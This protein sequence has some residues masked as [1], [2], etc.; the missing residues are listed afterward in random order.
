M[1]RQYI[2]GSKGKKP[3]SSSAKAPVEAPNTLQSKNTAGIIDLISE[4]EIYGLVNGAKSIFFD[5][6]PL[7]NDDDSYNFNGVVWEEKKGTPDDTP[8][9]GFPY[10][11]TEVDVGV[12]L[13]KTNPITRQ[14]LDSNLDAIRV[15][16]RIPQLTVANTSTGD[17]SGGTVSFQIEVQSSGGSYELVNF[18]N[19]ANP[20]VI[21]GK[22]TTPY[23][24]SYRVP[25]PAGGAPWNIRLT[26]ITDDSDVT[27]IQNKTFWSTYTKVIDSKLIYPDSAKNGLKVDAELFGNSIPARAYHVKGLILKVPSNYDPITREYTG[28]WDGTFQLAWSNNP[29][30]VLYDLMSSSRYGLGEYVDIDEVDKFSLYEIAQ[31]CDELVDNGEGG[32]EPR[33]TFNAVINSRREAF[34]VFNAI[35]SNFRAMLYYGGSKTSTKGQLFVTQDSPKD[36]EMLVTNSNVIGGIFNY[37]GTGLKSRHSVAFVSWNDP[38]NF[39]RN[40]IEV[41]EDPELIDQY[42]YRQLDTAAYGCTSRAQAHRHGKWLLYTERNQTQTVNYKTGLDHAFARPGAI[43]AIADKHYQTVRAGGRILSIVS[44][45]SG[46]A[47]QYQGL[48]AGIPSAIPGSLKIYVLDSPYQFLAGQTYEL[49]LVLPDG[50]VETKEV[51]NPETLTDRITV[52]EDFSQNPII[53]A[54]W[55]LSG[56][57][58]PRQFKIIYVRETE[59]HIYEVMAL[60]H[61]PEKYDE[62]E[63]DY[64]VEKPSYTTIKTGALS[65]PTNLGFAEYLYRAGPSIK[66]AITVSWTA[67]SSDPRVQYYDVW[68]QGPSDPDYRYFNTVSGTSI[69][70]EDTTDGEYKF[71]IQAVERLG[72]LRSQVLLG[73]YEAQGQKDPPDDVENFRISVI[74]EN[75]HLSWDALANLNLSHYTIK[76]TPALTSYTW[77]S[78][79]II[80][81][82]VS[83]D[84]THIVL[85]SLIGTYS[86]KGVNF[87][88]VE[89]VNAKF[90]PTTIASVSGLNVVSTLT[91][92][93]SFA[94]VKEA[95][96]FDVSLTGLILSDVYLD[97]NSELASGYYY[98]DNTLDL[99]QVFTSRVTPQIDG[100]G[101]DL[102]DNV[103]LWPNV[104]LVTN[105]DGSDPSD[106]EAYLEMRYSQD[107]A[108]GTLTDWEK[109]II[110]DYTARY[111]EFRLKM[112][113][114]KSGITPVITGLKVTVDMPDRVLGDNNVTATGGTYNAVFSP[115]FKETPAIGVTADDMILGDIMQ[116]T[117]KSRS[118]FTVEFTNG[119]SGVTRTF[120][121]IAAGYGEEG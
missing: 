64:V 42:G 56:E 18:S 108:P 15:K 110:G 82:R 13:K 112:V 67:P 41:V 113:S 80:A 99:G 115:A 68:Y 26:R 12:E 23:E 54:E 89:S 3:S 73:S 81:E 44:T 92:D 38:T 84:A 16:I 7:Q 31:Y 34:D 70:L 47:G 30:W 66:S 4:G 63:K 121:W 95:V 94:G 69:N 105:V 9:S 79:S 117:S 77:G 27:S 14:I 29:A 103:D 60:E 5:E 24:V 86:I 21:T 53:G 97:T 55:I 8:L 85:P 83:K 114:K 65:M 91:E 46:S 74:K 57:V 28:A 1:D 90:I 61:A 2:S 62:I 20:I 71:K 109:V 25:L 76:F 58:A 72:G 96:E 101:S 78:S 107:G 48:L 37:S 118:G 11:E 6:T 59:P 116:I 52:V 39:Y 93:P 111:F 120:D 98:F 106:W 35:C 119:G 22:N 87:L 33:F 45:A 102:L 32:T 88:G 51:V 75:V 10:V 17:L 19:T 43:V 100:F 36:P 49:S 104:D 50:T 40:T